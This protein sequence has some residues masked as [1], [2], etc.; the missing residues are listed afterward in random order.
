MYVKREGGNITGAFENEQ[1]FASESIADNDAELIAF[2]NPSTS[3]E[4]VKEEARRRISIVMPG[5]MVDREVSGGTAIHQTVKDYAAN[6]RT[7]SATLEG[8]L[9]ADYTDDSHWTVAP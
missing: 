7:D 6:I 5:W 2:L 1:S 9:P 4:D 3:V 8:T